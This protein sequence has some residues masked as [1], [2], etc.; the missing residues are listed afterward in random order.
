MRIL[1]EEV[2]NMFNVENEKRSSIPKKLASS[3]GFTGI[4]VLHIYLYP[5]YEFNVI[6]DTVID[7]Y[8]TVPLNVVKNY[9]T[10]LLDKELLTT[11]DLDERLLEFPWTKKLK[12]SRIPTA[13]GKDRKGLCSWK[14]EGYQKFSFPFSKCC[15]ENVIKENDVFELVSMIGRLT[16]LHFHTGHDGWT[17]EMI[18][19]HMK[20]SVRLNVMMEEVHGL[21]MCTVSLHNLCHVHEDIVTFWQVIMYGVLYTNGP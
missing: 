21:K 17:E 20:L 18:Q 8:H 4:S 19:D 14:A 11:E 1:C 13:I 7:V 15:L 9:L 5:M 6:R 10:T 12:A 3:S 16:E 2:D